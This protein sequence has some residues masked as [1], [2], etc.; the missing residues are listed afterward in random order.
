[1]DAEGMQR[2]FNQFMDLYIRP[3]I[4]RRRESGELPEN[5]ELKLAQVLIS[6]DGRSP[7]VRLNEETKIIGLV[8]VASPGKV[9]AGQE[10]PPDKIEEIQNLTLTDEEEPNYGH[11]SMV[12]IT[13]NR[14][15]FT[16]DFR[17]NK[18]LA[19]G[20]LERAK[21]F[22]ET[23]KE[24]YGKKRY[25]PVVENLFACVEL[26]AKSEL[27]LVPD[28]KFRKKT[29]HKAIKARYNKWVEIG[30]ADMRFGRTLNKLSSLRRSA[31]YLKS[32]FRL[33][34]KETNEYLAVAEEMI[35]YVELRLKKK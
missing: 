35:E 10:V 4:D 8:K 16:F 5:F 15:I 19:R 34:E 11:L 14:W 13:E 18:G 33:S 30:N 31:R 32:R 7:V 25:A 17:Y 6:G 1:M 26:L 23:A 22:F 24:S 2:T 29:S 28:P 27:L 9:K 3:E 20:H 12:K 21:E